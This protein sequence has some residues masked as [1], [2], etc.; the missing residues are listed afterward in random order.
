MY[1]PQVTDGGYHQLQLQTSDGYDFA[2][3]TWLTCSR[4]R[5]GLVAKI[6]VTDLWQ[7]QGYGSRM[8]RRAMRGYETYTWV[9]TGQSPQGK[10]FFPALGETTG[11]AFT[12]SA[13]RC[14]HMKAV[15]GAGLGTPRTEPAPNDLTR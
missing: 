12:P 2:R 11:A 1:R 10:Q 4:C 6:R 14:P 15:R 7:R 9:T 3:L 8:M 13:P 5:I